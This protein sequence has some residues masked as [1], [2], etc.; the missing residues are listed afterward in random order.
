MN[1]N[2]PKDQDLLQQIKAQSPNLLVAFS[3]G[4]DSI[5]LM[6]H[7]LES[8]IYRIEDMKLYYMYLVPGLEFV[9]QSIRYFEDFFG[10]KIERIPHPSLIRMTRNLVYCSPERWPSIVRQKL[11]NADYSA[12]VDALRK[13]DEAYS[14]AFVAS[15]V[16]SCD[17]P[18]RR[19]A[20]SKYGPVN[21]TE[22]KVQ[23]IWDKNIAWVREVI[24]RNK[25]RL[26]VDYEMF[27]RSFDGIDYRFIA[28]IKQRFP[29]DY[30][31]IERFFPIVGAEIFRY[32]TVGKESAEV[33]RNE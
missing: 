31:T 25:V 2:W 29:K 5:A 13:R 23:L 15:G 7:I 3:C 18:L 14:N 27:G 26:P 21:H 1:T 33:S 16:R 28:P 19:I 10:A 11:K 20:L 8:G 22:R 24:A 32:E 4:K 30:E 6:L 9:E 17:S 12:F